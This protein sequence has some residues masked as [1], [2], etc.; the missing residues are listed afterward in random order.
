VYCDASNSND[1]D[2]KIVS[3]KWNFGDGK[4]GSGKT[5]THTYT[6]EGDFTIQLT[7]ED[8]DGDVAGAEKKVEIIGLRPPLN[9]KYIKHENRN[10]FSVEYLYQVTWNLNTWN[11]K[12]GNYIV[13]YKLYRKERGQNSYAYLTSVAAPRYYTDFEYIDRS[14]GSED[15]DYMYAVKSIDVSGRESGLSEIGPQLMMNSDPG[16]GNKP[17]D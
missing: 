13:K 17:I 4:S 7:V 12:Y 6:K 1:P 8:D 3:Y 9:L 15:K 5:I 2:G 14:L 10:L 16:T 11:E